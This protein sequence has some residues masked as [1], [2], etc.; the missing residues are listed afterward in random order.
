MRKDMLVLQ[1]LAFQRKVSRH[2][3]VQSPFVALLP[4]WHLRFCNKEATD[5]QWISMASECYSLIC[6]LVFHLFT[7]TTAKGSTTISSMHG[8][9]CHAM[10]PPRP[11]VLGQPL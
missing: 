7:T 10:C 4:S 3:M 8:W 11:L 6:L 9:W 2:F 5:T 1:I